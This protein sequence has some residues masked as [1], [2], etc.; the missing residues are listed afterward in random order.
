M[1]QITVEILERNHAALIA[2]RDGYL[3]EAE[4]LRAQATGAEGAI[5]IVEHL[6]ALAQ[7]AE[8]PH[9]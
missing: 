8:E 1:M 7:K 5:R 6:L 3:D 2:E 9:E 4:R